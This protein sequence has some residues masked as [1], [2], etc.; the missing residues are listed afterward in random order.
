MLFKGVPG[1]KTALGG[2]KMSTSTID[3]TGTNNVNICLY[4]NETCRNPLNKSLHL[5][6]AGIH[7][8]DKWLHLDETAIHRLNEN[9]YILLCCF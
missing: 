6:E 2:P 8:L 9:L 7:N 1:S 3:D 5:D 4:L